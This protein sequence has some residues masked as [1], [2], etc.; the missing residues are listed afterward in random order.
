MKPESL[1][2]DIDGT[3]W[4]SRELVARGYNVYLESIGREDL[5][6]N[7]EIFKSLFGK[8]DREIA[9][10]LFAEYPVPERY[11]LIAACMDWERRIM[12]DD[13]CRVEYEGVVEVL[14]AL[15]R[16]YRL[17]L[18]S[19]CEAGYPE[20]LMDK[21]GIRHLFSGHL[22]HGETGLSKGETIRILMERQG[23][24]NAVYIGDTEGDR[25]A[26]R[27]AGIPFIFCA[28]GFGTPAE[29]DAKIGDIRQLPGVLDQL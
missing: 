26:S 5:C 6:V 1:I 10:V 11:D 19:N 18:V 7:A 2:F 29:Y 14:T 15:S 13:P 8:T 21:L 9:D 28:Y 20:L 3:L 27:H 23:I 22:C 12:E 24:E 17:Y 25:V 16:E 4:D